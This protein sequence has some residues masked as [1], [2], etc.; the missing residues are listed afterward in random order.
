MTIA[1]RQLRME[2]HLLRVGFLIG[3]DTGAADFRARSGR[4]RHGDDRRDRVAVGACPPVTDILEIPH[5]PRLSR[6]EGDQLAKIEC[7][8]TA[9]SDDAV[10]LA[11]FEYRNTSRQVRLDGIG[12]YFREHAVWH[13]GIVEDFQRTRHDR[14]LGEAGIG[15][16]Q[17]VLDPRRFQNLRQ[18]LDAARA[19]ADGGR[20][21][22]FGNKFAHV[23]S[24]SGN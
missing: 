6:L 14:Q 4:C 13:F 19:K 9:E 23:M 16:E 22:P 15:D 12:L 11:L 20:I 7:R 8:P 10:M 17:R 2:D 1:G 24:L 3:D 21:V 5:R 18:F